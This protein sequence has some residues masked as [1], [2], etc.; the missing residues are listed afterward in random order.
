MWNSSVTLSRLAICE[1]R[2]SSNLGAFS[3]LKEL[4]AQTNSL[5]DNYFL[6]LCEDSVCSPFSRSPRTR[7]QSSFTSFAG[8]VHILD[9]VV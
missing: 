1:L 9:A 7:L 6:S 5:Q 4:N 8:C 3:N 2:A